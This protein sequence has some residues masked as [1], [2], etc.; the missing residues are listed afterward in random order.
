[1]Q[2]SGK[3]SYVQ[4]HKN[5]SNLAVTTAKNNT[6]IEAKEGETEVFKVRVREIKT[7]DL[8]NA[9]CIKDEDG[10]LLIKET[11]IKEKSQ[12]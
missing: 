4:V 10:K 8:R 3:Q 9:R 5:D 7:W 12:I 1:M 6:Q 11:Q 2:K